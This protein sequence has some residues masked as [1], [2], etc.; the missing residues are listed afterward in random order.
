MSRDTAVGRYIASLREGAGFKQNEL[1]KRL[2]WSAAVLSRVESGDRPL[3]DDELSIV[4][5][6]IGTPEAERAQVLLAREWRLLPAP[7][8][9]DSDGDLLWEAEQTAQAIHALAER[10]DV[11]Q[12]FERRLV[13]YREEIVASASRVLEKRYRVAF[14]G[15][16]G[17]GK[18]TAI[19]RV[20]RLELPTTK[21]MP[22]AV[23]ET[24]AGGITICEV[25][26][27]R[28][29]GFG[30]LIEPC[31]EDE[32]R[33]SVLEFARFLLNAD[34]SANAGDDAETGAP[35][36]SREVERALRNMSG[37]KRKRAEKRPDGSSTP[38]ID[39]AR[40]LAQN[41]G[42]E[43]ALAIEI[44]ARMELH[45]RD[46][47][48]LWLPET[49]EKA[50]LDWLQSAFEQVNNG[51]H[52]EFS[53]PRRIELIVPDAILDESELE[54]TLVDTQGIDDIAERQDIEQYFDDPHAVM[55]L[56][57][58]FN[59]APSTS[60]RALLSRAKDGGARNLDVMSAVLALPRPGEAIV[61]RDDAG[62]AV[63]DAQGGY[64]L[65]QEQVALKL[66][67]L[68]LG[69][70]PVRFF[71]SAEDDPDALRRF[72]L[73]RV[74]AVRE[75]HRETLKEIIDGANALLANYEKEQAKEVMRA[76]ARSLSVWLTNNNTLSA[77]SKRHVHDSLVSATSSAHPR[78]IH[79]AVVREGD[80]PRLDYAHQLSH[81]A[82]AIATQ[83]VQPR[84]TGFKEVAQN[85]LNDE[86]YADAHDLVR[87]AM[88]AIDG[89]F[90]AMIRKVQLVGQSV[91]SDELRGDVEFWR[92]CESEWGRG[93]GY[94][95]RVNGRNRQWFE[96]AH[97]G[98]ADQRVFG[99][100]NDAWRDAVE[101]VSTLLVQD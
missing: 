28:G 33:R 21:G 9:N 97:N 60:V 35:G 24:G 61:M 41:F 42:D 66:H 88:R 11:K 8:L 69:G 71:N 101:S 62:D 40:V 86:Q 51:R 37:L 99:V 49:L 55:L 79:A 31:A 83:L 84:L 98:A 15:T 13:R 74:Q 80:W 82:R 68:G 23:L 92:N 52:A 56:C 89:G 94:R 57:T 91:H 54:I 75:S 16:I 3:S 36:I 64:D 6:G 34:Q 44:L 38:A 87:Q 73:G 93:G 67:P 90:D 2:E 30:L 65:K 77:P 27:R 46:R 96:T 76:A 47:R 7:S 18:S 29:P 72:I 14:V 12:F 53:I 45:K 50:P 78:T 1:A 4:L 25:H 17:V 10:P 26:V 63:E 85:L 100:V 39:E 48:D 22:K 43:K 58:S 20:Q 19:C 32:I 5:R 70:L 95:D 59:E 81:G